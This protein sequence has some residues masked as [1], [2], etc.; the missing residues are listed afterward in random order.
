MRGTVG[1]EILDHEK[2]VGDWGFR[3]HR[4]TLPALARGQWV[5][6]PRCFPYEWAREYGKGRVAPVQPARRAPGRSSVVK[7]QADA[8]VAPG[9]VRRAPQVLGIGRKRQLAAG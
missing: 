3:L 2:C 5:R 7:R 6:R 1:I 8:S 9:V 4:R